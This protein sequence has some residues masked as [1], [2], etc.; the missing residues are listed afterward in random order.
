[1][2]GAGTTPPIAGVGGLGTVGGAL[3]TTGFDTLGFALLA[4]AAIGAGL[5]LV[6]ESWLRR[7]VAP[8]HKR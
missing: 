6:R 7:S 5:L 4:L 3:A 8:S 2:Y 1:M